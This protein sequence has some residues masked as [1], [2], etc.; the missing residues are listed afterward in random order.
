MS[1]TMRAAVRFLL[2]SIVPA[3]TVGCMEPL[4]SGGVDI[5]GDP[6][7]RLGSLC[8]FRRQT[9]GFCASGEEEQA[10]A[11]ARV[12]RMTK[13]EE[14]LRGP[15]ASGQAGDY[16]LENNEIAV[17]ISRVDRTVVSSL[18]GAL[19]DAG[20]ARDRVDALGAMRAEI[21]DGTGTPAY[22]A[23]TSGVGADGSAW[24]E[25]SGSRLHGSE[26][27]GMRVRTRYTL[28]PG[29][30][31]VIVSTAVEGA[32][33]GG[34]E[35]IDL[36]DQICWGG[37]TP[38]APA[39]ALP[40]GVAIDPQGKEALRFNAPYVLG[41][42]A[43][44]GYAV[45]ADGSPFT[46]VHVGPC[47]TTQLARGRALTPGA[48]VSYERLFVVAPRGDTAAVATELFFLAGGS[49]GGVEIDIAWGASGAA[50][51]GAAGAGAARVGARVLLERGASQGA[52]ETAFPDPSPLWLSVPREG[53]AGGELPPG[54]YTLRLDG[55]GIASEPVVASVEAGK[56]TK[57]SLAVIPK[58]A[59]VVETGASA[60]GAAPA[61]APAPSAT[62]PRHDI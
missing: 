34:P 28:A 50:G 37:A 17:V 33:D 12:R 27:M 38:G 7:E 1:K 35:A 57:V 41:V 59:P 31:A 2:A 29:A 51:S 19:L 60:P 23:I 49:P 18:R 11:G 30:R 9:D 52:E 36:G 21:G 26:A 45:T 39:G 20:S 8:K 46:S 61:A 32:G 55:P 10:G 6:S 3:A 42:G 25:A 54:Q 4:Q 14:G 48:T 62:G 13:A 16:L 15:Y 5:L 44:V 22:D 40:V 56:V 53:V 43:A 58:A 24:V 47:T